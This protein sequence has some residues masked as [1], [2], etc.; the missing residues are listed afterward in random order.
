MKE[1]D[2]RKEKEEHTIIEAWGSK[3]D[4]DKIDEIAFMAIIYS[5]LEEEDN[6]SKVSILELKEKLHL[7][8]KTKLVSLISSLIHDFQ[9]LT[10]NRDGMLNSLASLKFDLSDLKSCK[11]IVEE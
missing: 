1:K 6:A 9:E 10:S 2:K 4:E 5:N 3:S 7:F 11:N 8:S